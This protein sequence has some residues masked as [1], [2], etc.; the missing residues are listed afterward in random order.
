M[1]KG[2]GY[3]A[4]VVVPPGRLPGTADEARC[5]YYLERSASLATMLN[6]IIGYINAANVVKRAQKEGKSIKEVVVEQGIMS[7]EAF[8]RLIAQSVPA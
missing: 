2:S 6:P 4:M 8:D 3:W 5:R 1:W 7:A